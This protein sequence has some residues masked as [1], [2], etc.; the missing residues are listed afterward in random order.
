MKNKTNCRLCWCIAAVGSLSTIGL[1]AFVGH[2]W[3]KVASGN[4]LET[5]FTGWG[6]QFNYVGFLVLVGVIPV[7]LLLGYAVRYWESRHER[8]FMKRYR[9][10]DHQG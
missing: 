9:I 2:A 8:E 7:A 10:R 4:G 3:K 6:V 1:I 5:Y